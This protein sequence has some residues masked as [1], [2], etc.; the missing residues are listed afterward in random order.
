MA[1]HLKDEAG[2]YLV[3]IADDH[4]DRLIIPRSSA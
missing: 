1:G 2:I 4:Y 3:E